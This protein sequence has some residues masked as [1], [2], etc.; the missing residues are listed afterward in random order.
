MLITEINDISK[1]HLGTGSWSVKGLKKIT[2][3]FGKNG[4][5]KSTILE[6]LGANFND[7][8]VRNGQFVVN[9]LP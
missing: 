4:S 2:V 3:L 6:W 1:G 9:R 7:T 5:R 8:D